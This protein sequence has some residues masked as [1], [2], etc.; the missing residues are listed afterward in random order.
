MKAIVRACTTG[1]LSASARLLISNNAT[2]EAMTWAR[3]QSI[4]C[5][6]LSG[7]T[8]ATPSELDLAIADALSAA[9]VSLIV[10][11][12]Y[13]RK[14]GS[15]TV[16]RYRDRILNV[17][18]ALL[19]RYCGHGMFGDHVHSRVLAAGERESGATVHLVDE[20]YD[21]GPTIA[22]GT[23]PVQADDTLESLRA[24]VQAEEQRLLVD[25]LCRM[26]SGAIRLDV[27]AG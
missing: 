1:E 18:P 26:A 13:M 4:E 21:H 19:P 3:E 14:L 23:V 10:L 7:R 17:H 8:H 20:E 12:G 27:S 25:T 5:R 24:R 6:H 11:S 2:C 15:E 22:Q 16:R 9:G